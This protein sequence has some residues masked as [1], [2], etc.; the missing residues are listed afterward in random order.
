MESFA[1]MTM[2]DLPVRLLAHFFDKFFACSIIKL[3]TAVMIRSIPLDENP[4]R[5]RNAAG[6]AVSD[7]LVAERLHGAPCECGAALDMQHF[8]ATAVHSLDGYR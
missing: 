7:I 8:K 2:T 3:S 5:F 1:D 6:G 4:Q